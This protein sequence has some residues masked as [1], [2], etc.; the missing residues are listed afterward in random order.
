[1]VLLN[2]S[3]APRNGLAFYNRQRPHSYCHDLTPETAEQLHY[4][5]IRTLNPEAAIKA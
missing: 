4:D 2:C 5:Q 1:M 3:W